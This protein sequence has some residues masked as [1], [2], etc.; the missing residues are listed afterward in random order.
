MYDEEYNPAQR[1]YWMYQ[2][3]KTFHEALCK[4]LGYRK[5]HPNDRTLEILKNQLKEH[6]A[7]LKGCIPEFRKDVHDIKGT[8]Q[9]VPDADTLA[10]LCGLLK[11]L[12]DHQGLTAALVPDQIKR[13]EIELRQKDKKSLIDPDQ[14]PRLPN[15]DEIGRIKRWGSATIHEVKNA[16]ALT[17][18]SVEQLLKNQKVRKLED[19]SGKKATNFK[20]EPF[21]FK[22][23]VER[24]IRR[25]E[26]W[27]SG[28]I[29]DM[30]LR[31]DLINQLVFSLMN[32][33][34]FDQIV[35]DIDVGSPR[36][37]AGGRPKKLH[38]E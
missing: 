7:H 3:G 2:N 23:L 9:Q 4:F 16:F 38:K 17:R 20:I 21:F 28:A 36:K 19:G 14:A 29:E 27:R 5:L 15:L 33:R 32:K 25:L 30:P 13:R 31:K 8:I 35:E 22:L 18:K 34:E 26:Y 11:R 37:H 1:V 10:A 24:S 12:L 6:E